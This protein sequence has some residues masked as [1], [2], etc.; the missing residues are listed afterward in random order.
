MS[1]ES[2]LGSILRTLEVNRR[3][4]VF[5]FAT[6]PLG[7]SLP[8]VPLSAMVSEADGTSLVLT[9]QAAD[10]AGLDYEFEAAWLSVVNHT[11]LEA[12]GVTAS[13]STALAMKGIPCNVIAG[14]HH[15]HILVPHDQA[16]EA[17]AAIDI[18]RQQRLAATD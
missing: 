10:D 12:V 6:V 11:S 13:I 1:G 4:G 18:L 5:V 16:D 7:E 8:D 17:M 14:F 9:R 2:D 3:D 15:D